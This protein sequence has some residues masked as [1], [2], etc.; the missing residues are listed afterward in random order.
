M[1]ERTIMKRLFRRLF[2]HEEPDEAEIGRRIRR[3]LKRPR[4]RTGQ[5]RIPTLMVFIIFGVIVWSFFK[6]PIWVGLS[7][8]GVTT[9][10]CIVDYFL[11]RYF[12]YR[13]SDSYKKTVEEISRLIEE[14]APDGTIDY[15]RIEDWQDD[16][17]GRFMTLYEEYEDAVRKEKLAS[18]DDSDTLS[19]TQFLKDSNADDEVNGI[20]NRVALRSIKR[21]DKEKEATRRAVDKVKGMFAHETIDVNNP[22]VMRIANLNRTLNEKAKTLQRSVRKREEGQ[23]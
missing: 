5:F 12:C 7:L 1:S 9:V 3:K 17:I 19:F 18:D 21:S 2:S 4:M 20:L 8:I 13:D 14:V 6:Y 22:E 23:Q 15:E 11:S 10:G 16:D